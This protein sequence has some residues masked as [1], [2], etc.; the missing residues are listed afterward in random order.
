MY[1]P[2]GAEISFH[3]SEMLRLKTLCM[4]PRRVQIIFNVI[5]SRGRNVRIRKPEEIL[6]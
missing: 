1:V 3:V 5:S 2:R 4:N 6:R